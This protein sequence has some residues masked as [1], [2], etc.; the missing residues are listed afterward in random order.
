[1]RRIMMIGL[2]LTGTTLHAQDFTDRAKASV[3]SVGGVGNVVNQGNL[4]GTV[5]PYETDNPDEAK[6]KP[7]QFEDE[8]FKKIQSGGDEGRAYIAQSDSAT[9]R[10]SVDLGD[11]P[12]SLADDAVEQ[13]DAVAGGLFSGAGGSCST[14]FTGGKFSG[15]QFCQKILKRTKQSCE[16]WRQITVDR[17]DRWQCYRETATY[18]KACDRNLSYVCTG[19]TGATCLSKLVSIS[20]NGSIS[21]GGASVALPSNP[22]GSCTIKEDT[23]VLRVAGGADLRNIIAD[24]INYRGIA[25]I[26]IDG[27]VVA[28]TRRDATT[29]TSLAADADLRVGKRDCGKNCSKIAIYAGSTH[30][31]DCTSKQRTSSLNLSL[32]NAT[33]KIGFINSDGSPTSRW[34]PLASSAFMTKT[35]KEIRVTI[36]RGNKDDASTGLGFRFKSACCSAF[37]P[38]L[39]GQC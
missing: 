4:T 23:V 13:S 25:Q 1:M 26:V 38:V 8:E 36:R 3:D 30:I 29:D 31:E 17:K 5:T 32:G 16:V 18:K 27:K 20:P 28:T 33:P 39:G 37:K 9:S 15:T 24:T 11:D 6:L 7:S 2:L 12:L 21:T 34:P 19:Y 10:P 22:P 14:E 35:T